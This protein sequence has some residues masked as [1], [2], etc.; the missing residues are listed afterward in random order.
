MDLIKVYRLEGLPSFLKEILQQ[1]LVR[2]EK[3]ELFELL[4]QRWVYAEKNTG[5]DTLM[6]AMSVQTKGYGVLGT[7]LQIAENTAM[8]TQTKVP[9]KD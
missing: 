2:Q 1:S 4:S 5:V 6:F 3:T 8:C 9:A 7:H